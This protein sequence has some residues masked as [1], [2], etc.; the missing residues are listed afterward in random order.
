M[1][2]P[3]SFNVLWCQ[4]F[5]EFLLI[6]LFRPAKSYDLPSFAKKRQLQV[7]WV[8]GAVFW[9]YPKNGEV[10]LFWGG[11]FFGTISHLTGAR[12][13]FEDPV[14]AADL[15]LRIGHVFPWH[16]WNPLCDFC[17]V[18]FGGKLLHSLRIAL[19]IDSYIGVGVWNFEVCWD[20]PFSR[21]QNIQATMCV[22]YSNFYP[23]RA[24]MSAFLSAMGFYGC[25]STSC[26]SMLL[27]GLHDPTK[28]SKGLAISVRWIQF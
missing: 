28:S 13:G 1:E 8:I 5:W 18:K 27:M 17:L 24:R 2:Y 23:A 14:V 6:F 25:V 10:F 20:E 19:Q 3:N 4:Y 12:E 21:T 26:K 7:C 11:R 9:I 22:I 15:S 16:V